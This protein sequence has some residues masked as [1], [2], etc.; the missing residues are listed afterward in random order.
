[1]RQFIA[2][3][4]EDGVRLS[5]FVLQ[6]THEFPSAL[7]YKSFRNKRIKVN[8]KRAEADTRLCIGDLIELYINDEFFGAP[9]RSYR[10]APNSLTALPL[11]IVW[12]NPD[13]AVLYKPAGL[14]CHSDATGD[15]TLLDA[16]EQHLTDTGEFC[17]QD[18]LVFTPAL[19][20]RLDRGTEG[21]IIGAKT[22]PALRDMNEIIRLDLLQ[23]TYLCITESIPP[24]GEC[25]AYLTRNKAS[26]T[27]LVSNTQLPGSK[28]I[29]TQIKVKE[30]HRNFAL[31]EIALLTGRTHQIRAHLSFLGAPL[32][33]D[34]KYGNKETNCRHHQFSQL[35][36]AHHL[37]FSRLL[38]KT[39]GMAALAGQEFDV[40]NPTPLTWW[41]NW[42]KV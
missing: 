32:L 16:F 37:R 5:R 34:T 40:P 9:S 31:C 38:P 27:S 12:Q 6:V 25:R 29:V 28:P 8:G 23:K 7:L 33:G 35:L 20:H 11:A 13:I 14:L 22:Q 2:G 24:Q 3:P 18:E 15:S 17:P 41:E 21:L 39:N 1:M 4:N 42:K 30:T 10:P 26:R 19:C 36:C